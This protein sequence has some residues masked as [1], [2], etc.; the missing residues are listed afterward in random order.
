[1]GS[2]GAVLLMGA[3]SSARLRL[4]P[5]LAE[6]TSE[7]RWIWP[8]A[9][10][11]MRDAPDFHLGSWSRGRVVPLGDAGYCGSPLSGQGASMA[12]VGAYVLKDY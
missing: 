11:Y 12:M 5:L 1:M 2:V 7:T 6:R 3:N 9:K 4:V 10:A 8:R